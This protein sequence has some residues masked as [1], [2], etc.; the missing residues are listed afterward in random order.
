MNSQSTVLVLGARGRLGS[1]AVR[2]FAR[3]GW[4]VIAQVRPGASASAA[5]AAAHAH[6]PA[7]RWLAH[8][9]ADTAGLAAAA[10]GANVVVH[11]L[12]PVYTHAAWQ[13]EAPVLM[14][15]AIAVTR[16]LSMAALA[17]GGRPATLM[18]PGNVYNFGE[19]LPPVLREDTPQAATGLKGRVRIALESQLQAATHDGRLRA[20]VIRAGDYFGSGTGAW[21]DQAIAKDMARGRVTWPGP[22]DVATPWAYL[23]DLAQCFVQVAQRCDALAGFNTF[24][25]AGHTVTGA[26]WVEVLTDIAWEQGWLPPGG[27]LKVGHL[28]WPLLRAFGLI[29]AKFEALASMRYLWAT[30]HRL[31]Q[32]RLEA[33]IGPVPQTAFADAVRAALA[34]LGLLAGPHE[35][36]ALAGH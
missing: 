11:A 15:V 4:R 21:L 26:Q 3:A 17:S 9:L 12:N 25:F 29:N 23:P 18:L 10:A 24:H 30:A 35:R 2:A 27:Q 16:A 13:R 7:L 33:L 22:L 19:S 31:D 8:D 1:A 14:D 20:V 28:P 6:T 36:L 5:S 32:T 34:D